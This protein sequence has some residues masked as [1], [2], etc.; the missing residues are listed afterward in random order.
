MNSFLP[1]PKP[2]PFYYEHLLNFMQNSYATAETQTQFMHSWRSTFHLQYLLCYF[3]PCEKEKS[4][5]FC[6]FDLL[7]IYLQVWSL[8]FHSVF[9]P[10]KVALW[11]WTRNLDSLGHSLTFETTGSNQ[12]IFKIS[13]VSKLLQMLTFIEHLVWTRHRFNSSL[14]LTS[15]NSLNNTLRQLLVLSAFAD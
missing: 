5:W 7:G 1:T 10:M 12:H 13:S 15:F 4:D 2:I 11:P 6:I 9:Q 3:S 8:F 14:C